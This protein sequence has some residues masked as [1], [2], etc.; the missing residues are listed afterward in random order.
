MLESKFKIAI[1]LQYLS[2]RPV[3]YRTQCK[4]FQLVKLNDTNFDIKILTW[5]ALQ[6]L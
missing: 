6:H 2:V 1:R 5:E 3:P 4:P